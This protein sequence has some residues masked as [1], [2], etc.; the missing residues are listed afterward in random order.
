M[1]LKPMLQDFPKMIAVVHSPLPRVLIPHAFQKS[2]CLLF[3]KD[4]V[5]H[6]LCSLTLSISRSTSRSNCSLT[7][8]QHE[9]ENPHG[10]YSQSSVY[11]VPTYLFPLYL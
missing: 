3:Q 11:V 8:E 4:T 7:L 9:I 10:A 5:A 1:L 6:V 2:E